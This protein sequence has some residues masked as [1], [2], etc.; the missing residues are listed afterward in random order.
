MQHFDRAVAVG[1]LRSYAHLIRHRSDFVLARQ[2][3]LISE[4]VDWPQWS[5]FI[6]NFRYIEDVYVSKRYQYGQLRLSRLNWAVRLF[7]PPSAKTV[8]YYEIPYWSI[9]VY[10]RRY[11]APLI[12]LFASISMVLSSMQ[13][14]LSG[15]MGDHRI[16]S[17]TL[18]GF[19][20]MAR[21]FGGF[22]ILV[23]LFLAMTWLLLIVTP[24]AVLAW[25]VSWGYR[26]R[27]RV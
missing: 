15:P 18:D 8:W 9:Q 13:V 14:L 17:T 7:R 2:Y 5:R 20:D 25:Q 4:T 11:T 12:F 3:H 26:H 21:A 24:L 1:F 6:H 27:E 10:T 16:L 23:L 22:S 19:Q